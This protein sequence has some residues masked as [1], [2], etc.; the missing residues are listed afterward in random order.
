M[1]KTKDPHHRNPKQLDN[2]MAMCAR[3]VTSHDSF[4]SVS[5]RCMLSKYLYMQI[6]NS[7]V[8]RGSGIYSPIPIE[9]CRAYSQ[10]CVQLQPNIFC[11][12][13]KLL[14]F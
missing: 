6:P 13:V 9:V 8:Q 7:R 2:S 4:A 10:D 3:S 14:R 11:R 5:L 1:A 12:A